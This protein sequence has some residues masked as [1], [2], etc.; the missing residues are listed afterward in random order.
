MLTGDVLAT[1]EMLKKAHLEAPVMSFADFNQLFLLTTDT[2]KLGLGAV[3]SQKQT[4]GRYHPVAYASWSL[5][6]HEHNYHSTTQ[7]FLALKWG[8]AQKF[9]E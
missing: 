9:Q 5:T 8:I 1:F 2:G 3:L 6:V 4:D 7:E